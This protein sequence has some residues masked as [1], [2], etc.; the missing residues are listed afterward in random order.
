MLHAGDRNIDNNSCTIKR[1]QLGERKN[2]QCPPGPL[3]Y[4]IGIGGK[5]REGGPETQPEPQKVIWGHR[6]VSLRSGAALRTPNV[7]M[8]SLPSKCISEQYF[9]FENVKKRA[10]TESKRN[11]F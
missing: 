6:L 4:L 10:G 3:A 8:P 7:T 5:K 11:S 9:M 1:K 2:K